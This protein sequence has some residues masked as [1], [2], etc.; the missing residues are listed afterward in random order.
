MAVRSEEEDVMLEETSTNDTI[1][2]AL[3]GSRPARAAANVAIQVAQ[4][5]HLTV[6]GLHIVDEPLLLDPY[7]SYRPELGTTRPPMSPTEAI[8]AFRLHGEEVLTWL[9]DRCQTAHVPVTSELLLEG[10]PELVLQEADPV[11][12]L[13]LGRRGLGHADDPHHLGRYFRAIAHHAPCPFIAGGDEERELRRLL[14]AYDGSEQ[15]R[16]A[17]AWTLR[18]QHAL[19]TDVTV[20]AIKQPD[21]RAAHERL[22]EVQEKLAQDDRPHYRLLARRGEPVAEIIHAA[23]ESQADCILMGGYSLPT[24]SSRPATNSSCSRRPKRGNGSRRSV[25]HFR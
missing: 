22:Q 9:E 15:S 16:P 19:S 6:R 5:Q 12:L 23:T 8:T 14:L 25:C 20:P 10:V 3:D 21:D 7:A 24:R 4:A 17:L 2:V 18:L 11:L 1:L 13:G